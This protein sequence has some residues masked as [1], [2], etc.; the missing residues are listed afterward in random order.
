[1]TYFDYQPVAEEAG[2]SA[3]DLEEL[4]RQVRNE[5]PNDDMLFELHML[6]ACN[7]VRDGIATI[8][9][10]LHDDSLTPAGH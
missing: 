8:Q 2:I 3:R 6:R 5:F 9:Q 10:I 1:M 4:R 7:T